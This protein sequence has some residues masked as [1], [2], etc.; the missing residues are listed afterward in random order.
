[1]EPTIQYQNII[2]PLT[3]AFQK[4]H[5]HLTRRDMLSQK[6]RRAIEKNAIMWLRKFLDGC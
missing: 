2:I 1:M 6:K 3:K 5:I 4:Y